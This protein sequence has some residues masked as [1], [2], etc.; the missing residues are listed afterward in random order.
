MLSLSLEKGQCSWLINREIQVRLYRES[1]IGKKAQ[2]V[3][4]EEKEDEEKEEDEEEEEDA[5][6]NDDE[7][8]NGK[9]K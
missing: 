9:W 1:A 8:E 7:E 5:E 3:E 2:G 6:A 4:R